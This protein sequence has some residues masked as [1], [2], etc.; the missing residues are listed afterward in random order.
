[1]RERTNHRF[2]FGGREPGQGFEQRALGGASFFTRPSPARNRQLANSLF[3]Q[4]Q[5]LAF[6]LHQYFTQ[7]TAQP[8][9]IPAERSIVLT[10]A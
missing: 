9:D 5:R 6:E 2:H 8:P 7:E 1:M 4:E 10:T 3:E